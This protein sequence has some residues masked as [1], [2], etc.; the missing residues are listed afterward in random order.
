MM[1]FS[2]FTSK[3]YIYIYILSKVIAKLCPYLF[4]FTTNTSYLTFFIL[5]HMH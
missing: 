5:Q 3:I 1:E 2:K 4:Y